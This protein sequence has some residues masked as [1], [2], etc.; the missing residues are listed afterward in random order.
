MCKLKSKSNNNIIFKS[1]YRVWKLQTTKHPTVPD[2]PI[3]YST[4]HSGSTN[5][6]NLRIMKALT[7]PMESCTFMYDIVYYYTPNNETKI[8][9]F[10]SKLTQASPYATKCR[11][12]NIVPNSLTLGP[13]FIL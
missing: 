5:K 8:H 10:Y 3:G 9:S 7:Y 11:L 12:T 2:S 4:I 1:A 6:L 13:K